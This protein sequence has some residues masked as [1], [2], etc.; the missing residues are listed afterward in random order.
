MMLA[1]DLLQ[2]NAGAVAEQ[3][4]AQELLAYRD[5]Y[6][7]ASL[8][9]WGR[10]ARNSRAEVDYLIACGSRVVPIEV[11]AGKTG[12]LRSLRLFQEQYAA[13]GGV[14]ISSRPF[15][16]SLPVISLP[17]YAQ[18]QLLKVIETLLPP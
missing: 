17:L 10:E 4:V 5:P 9:Y 3:L 15:D 6:Q 11:K 1:D 12:T 13:P 14:R 16:S 2:L 18:E 8:Y 7:P